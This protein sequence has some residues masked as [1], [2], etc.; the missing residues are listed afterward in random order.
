MTN[1]NAGDEA[2]R[3]KDH[4]PADTADRRFADLIRLKIDRLKI[5]AA[6]PT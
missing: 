3:R 4:E 5:T 2:C 6:Y 1:F